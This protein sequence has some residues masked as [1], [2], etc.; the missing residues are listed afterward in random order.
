MEN[1]NM[2]PVILDVEASGFGRGSY[3]IEVGVVM[4]DQV[5]HCMLIRPELEWRHWDKAAEQLHCITREQLLHYGHPAREVAHCL[6]NWLG[7]QLVYSDAWGN[8]SSWLALLFEAAQCRQQFKL[9]SLR[10][11]LTDRQVTLW[12]QSKDHII[13]AGDFIR[14]RASNDAVV[15]QRTYQQTFQQAKQSTSSV[16]L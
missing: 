11:L 1:K 15:L 9:E 10:S 7:G 8:D 6:N 4:A 12:H 5:S 16:D 3:P 2:L 14:H 13:S